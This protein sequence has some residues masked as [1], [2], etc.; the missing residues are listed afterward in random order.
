MILLLCKMLFKIFW[1][2]VI[3]EDGPKNPN[4]TKAKK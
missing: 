4:I 3:L 2:R 1:K